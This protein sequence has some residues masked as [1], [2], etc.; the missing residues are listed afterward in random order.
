LQG[1]KTPLD[2]ARKEEV[3]VAL[4]E[5]GGKHSLFYAAEK[6]MAELVEE[7]HGGGRR[8]RDYKRGKGTYTRKDMHV[9][10]RCPLTVYLMLPLLRR[11]VLLR[12]RIVSNRYYY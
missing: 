9:H 2:L 5:H 4:R 1:G 10:I 3:K 7:S 8:C 12:Q 11:R 6:G